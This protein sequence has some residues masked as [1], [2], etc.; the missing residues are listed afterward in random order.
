LSICRASSNGR[1]RIARSVTYTSIME[2]WKR[3]PEAICE[4][5]VNSMSKRGKAVLEI[6]GGHNKY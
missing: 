1:R 5:L 4:A 6:N 3:T 2:E